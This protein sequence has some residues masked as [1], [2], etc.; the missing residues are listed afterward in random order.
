MKLIWKEI[1]IVLLVLSN[2]ALAAMLASSRRGASADRVAGNIANSNGGMLETPQSLHPA[3]LNEATGNLDRVEGAALTIPGI[4]N[5]GYISQIIVDLYS[6]PVTG[7][8]GPLFVLPK[9]EWKKSLGFFEKCQLDETNQKLAEIGTMKIVF[10]SGAV[11]RICIY[12]IGHRGTLYFSLDG[13]RY[14]SSGER[15]ANDEA[16]AVYAHLFQI[17]EQIS[18]KRS[19]PEF[20]K[21]KG[22]RAE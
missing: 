11:H 13:V 14:Q 18:Q 9:T 12:W 2:F 21:E 4:D 1:T 10:K 16:L 15:F 8:Q 3:N 7:G 20:R 22:D 5:T 6:D 17:G 19:R